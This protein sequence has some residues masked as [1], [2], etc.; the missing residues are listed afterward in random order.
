[1]ALAVAT[2]GLVGL[3]LGFG[4]G[5]TTFKRSLTWCNHCGRRL[6]C[7]NCLRVAQ[8]AAPRRMQRYSSEPA[9][10]GTRERR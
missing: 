8:T 7:L 5:F 6:Q 10:A 2:A 9:E 4:A 1:M 3:L